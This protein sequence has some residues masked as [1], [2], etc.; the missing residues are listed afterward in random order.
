MDPFLRYEDGTDGVL[1]A[2]VQIWLAGRVDDA[3]EGVCGGDELGDC[4]GGGEGFV[5]EDV[6]CRFV[7]SGQFF[8]VLCAKE[9]V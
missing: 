9:S 5:G 1:G 7:Y 2:W 8:V 3:G 4:E 6:D